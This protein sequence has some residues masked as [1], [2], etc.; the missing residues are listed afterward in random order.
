MATRTIDVYAYGFEQGTISDG[1]PTWSANRVRSSV[2]IPLPTTFVGRKLTASATVSTGK[3]VQVDMV[4]FVTTS[5]PDTFDL[6]WYNSP[7]TFDLSSY[8]TTMYFKMCLKYSDN[9]VITPSEI[10]SCKVTYDDGIDFVAGSD[11]YLVPIANP[12][13]P[14]AAM[15]QP[16]PASLWRVEE[17]WNDGYLFHELQRDIPR[18]I[19]AFTGAADLAAVRIPI[20]VKVIGSEAFKDTA[21]QRVRIAADCTYSEQSFPG[22][23]VV[24]RYPD[25]RYEQLYDC[26]GKA[27]LDYDGARVYVLK[28][29][30]NNG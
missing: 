14:E 4:G 5:P 25:D 17:G 11:G 15:V 7:Y 23:C 19:G 20:S 3:T 24:T 26:D 27:V 29:D 8:Q 22:G 12:T 13:Y 30:N 2:Y 10:T 18:T 16:Y 28:E 1:E 21:L 9:T 6:C